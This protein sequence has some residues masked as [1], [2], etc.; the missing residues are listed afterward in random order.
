MK[1]KIYLARHGSHAELGRVLSGR[2]DIPL[3]AQGQAEANALAA[4]LADGA[5]AS[6]HSSPRRRARETAM[7]VAK[8]SGLPVIVADALDEIDFGRFSGATFA[9]LEQDPSWHRWNGERGTARCPEGETMV[10]ATERA[11]AYIASLPETQTP[12]LCVTHC[13]IIRGL[14]AAILG[15]DWQ[16]IFALDCDPGS[17]TVIALEGSNARLLS[18]NEHPRLIGTHQPA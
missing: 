13:D 12:A 15:L 11:W 4:H 1:R 7:P 3:N 10:E 5:I 18:L 8:R 14:I 17:L 9:Q 16:R 6:I 2:S